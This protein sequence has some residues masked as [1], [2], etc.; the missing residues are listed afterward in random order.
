MSRPALKELTID[1]VDDPAAPARG[2]SGFG[3]MDDLAQ[4]IAQVGIIEP[5]V[6]AKRGA[7]FEVVAGHRRLIAARLAGLTTVPCVV[8]DTFKTAEEAVTL[9]ENIHRADLNPVD[10][11]RFFG[12][13]LQRVDGDTERLAELVRERR[14]YVEARL[15][16]LDGDSEVLAAL[17]RGDISLGVAR[18]LNLYDHEP[19][20]RAHLGAAIAGGSKTA[21]VA[22]WRKQA[23]EFHRL[24]LAQDSQVVS[25]PEP[26]PAPAVANPFK[27]FY[28]ASEEHVHM[29]RQIYIH[30]PC[31]GLLRS[32]LG[33]RA[34]G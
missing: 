23:N 14:D 2:S 34:D 33:V 18:E 10:E 12:R 27:C 24:Q 26:T 20:R 5:L 30:E 8:H 11:A 1:Q 29:M 7:R 21:L 15:Q 17:E 6:V 4:S 28:C 22:S 9:H 16:L 3:D 25:A 32:A 13:L 19:T 31:I